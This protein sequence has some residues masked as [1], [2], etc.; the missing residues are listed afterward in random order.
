MEKCWFDDDCEKICENY[1]NTISLSGFCSEKVSYLSVTRE[2]FRKDFFN[3]VQKVS[4]ARQSTPH[5]KKCE[6]YSY[7]A[8]LYFR[9]K[10]QESLNKEFFDW[11]VDDFLGDDME[12]YLNPTSG[13]ERLMGFFH[14]TSQQVS[15]T[16]QCK[17]Q[18]KWPDEFEKVDIEY[19]DG[20]IEF[21]IWEEL[22][23]A[24][25]KDVDM[26]STLYKY[27]VMGDKDMMRKLI[28]YQLSDKSTITPPKNEIDEV[29]QDEKAMTVL[30]KLTSGFGDSLDFEITLKDGNENVFTR[31]VTINEDIIFKVSDS[32][33]NAKESELDF[34]ATLTL[35]NLYDFAKSMTAIDSEKVYGPSWVETKEPMMIGKRIGLIF[36]LWNSVDVD[37]WT[38]KLKLSTKIGKIMNYMKSLETKSAEEEKMIAE[39]N[40]QIDEEGNI[41]QQESTP[42]NTDK[43]ETISYQPEEK[44][45]T[46]SDKISFNVEM[47]YQGE[48][49]TM[50]YKARNLDSDTPDFKV[51][52][53]DGS[54]KIVLGSEQISW[55]TYE[56][57][58]GKTR[59][60]QD[61]NVWNTIW[62]M[63][64]TNQF[65]PFYKNALKAEGGE[66]TA[67][68]ESGG[69]R[70]YDIN[71]EPSFSGSVF[72]PE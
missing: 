55:Y 63:Q 44:T 20:N 36:K 11:Y 56:T 40:T 15:N 12:K 21:H 42:D 14:Q 8:M 58:E 49:T 23:S 4:S 65:L 61:A 30:E 43:T 60:E 26:W 6:P 54:Q 51:I 71:K 69:V 16:L 24:S 50:E 25:H 47:A 3:F 13:F 5:T 22:K 37:P 57:P 17:G 45:D 29:K 19:K 70:I 39:L 10:L 28:E 41:K 48:T 68:G 35:D 31:Y 34:A 67:S 64:Y 38:T 7:E 27:K 72:Q 1:P 53:D 59:W 52:S 33:T 66:Y 62:E 46:R 9:E 32:Q 2:G 18:N